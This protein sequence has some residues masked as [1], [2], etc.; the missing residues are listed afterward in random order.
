[1]ENRLKNRETLKSYFQ[2]GKVPTEEQFA[3][4]I[5]SLHNISEDGRLT[6]TA[7]DGLILYPADR[8]RIFAS[9]F[10]RH[11]VSSDEQPQWQFSL[12][13]DGSLIIGR[14]QSVAFVLGTDGHLTLSGGL[15][16]GDGRLENGES[17]V[18]DR[19]ELVQIKADG[20]WHDLPIE[21][22]VNRKTDGCRVYRISACL[23]HLSSGKYAV[24]EATASHSGGTRRRISSRRK[25]WWGWSGR[26]RMRWQI[27]DR[28]LYLQIRSCWGKYG[29]ENISCR[30]E[31]LWDV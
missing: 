22:A 31:T 7:R 1:M 16:T 10:G 26:I 18:P 13:E 29:E 11:P 25:H 4:L 30:I 8:E 27:H 3:A 17:K 5:D 6:V 12:A 23:Y 9:L 14:G 20:N 15:Q 19:K 2:R 24:C 21:A 28:K